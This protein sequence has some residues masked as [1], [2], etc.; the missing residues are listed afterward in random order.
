MLCVT[1]RYLKLQVTK[2][3]T[4]R[5]MRLCYLHIYRV[6]TDMDCCY[7]DWRVAAY[8]DVRRVCV[9]PVALTMKYGVLQ[10]DDSPYYDASI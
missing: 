6:T 4:G 2:G 5:S 9:F 3:T 8:S 10:I 7:T 1:G